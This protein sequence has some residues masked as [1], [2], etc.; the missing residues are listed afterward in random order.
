M[1]VYVP[2]LCNC[3]AEMLVDSYNLLRKLRISAS[4]L[5]LLFINHKQPDITSLQGLQHFM[6]FFSNSKN[7]VQGHTSHYAM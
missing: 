2:E 1:K 7:T 4:L 3:I 5:L 6:S